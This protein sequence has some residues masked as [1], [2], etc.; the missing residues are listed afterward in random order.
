MGGA[1]SRLVMS[2]SDATRGKEDTPDERA[3]TFSERKERRGAGDCATR[4]P[5]CLAV[6]EK[7]GEPREMGQ[8]GGKERQAMQK[9]ANLG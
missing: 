3:W 6:Q 1:D 7:Q 2:G 5:A 9:Q 4:S 8:R